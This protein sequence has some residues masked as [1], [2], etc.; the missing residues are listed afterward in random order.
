MDIRTL[1]HS[2]SPA[3]NYTDI[4][5]LIADI[6][7]ETE[8]EPGIEEEVS[9]S[10]QA[11]LD[12]LASSVDQLAEYISKFQDTQDKQVL[13]NLKS[14][15]G[16]SII[17]YKTAYDATIRYNKTWFSNLFLSADGKVDLAKFLIDAIKP[18]CP[19]NLETLKM[20]GDRSPDL[21]LFIAYPR[22]TDD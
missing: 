8:D 18:Y 19:S 14:Q 12:I 15:I 6:K 13:P 11:K 17:D 5:Q 10:I 1:L 4:K 9:E 20:I 21:T 2:I 7:E 22:S 3:S 16:D